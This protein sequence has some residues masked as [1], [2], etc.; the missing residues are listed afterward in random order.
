MDLFETPDEFIIRAEVAGVDPKDLDIEVSGNALRISGKRA[1]VPSIPG[2]TYRL[3]E[4]QNGSFERVLKLP[5]T[6]DTAKVTA[7]YAHGFLK[8][9]LVKQSC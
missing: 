1:E 9:N 4:I 2:A 5:R 3:V 8:I 7:E 6:V